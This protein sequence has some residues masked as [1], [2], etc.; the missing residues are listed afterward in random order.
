MIMR[1][2]QI[3]SALAVV[4]FIGCNNNST[5]EKN[6]DIVETRKLEGEELVKRGHYLVTVATCGDCHSPKT[7][8][9]HGPVIDSTKMLSGSPAGMPLP[10]FNPNAVKPGNWMNMSPDITVFVGPWG[11]S[12]AANLTPDSATGIGTWTEDL[13]IKALRTGKHMGAENGRPILPPMPWEFV[14]KMT[15]EDLRSVFAYLKSLPAI[16]NKVRAPI[17]PNE[18]K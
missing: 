12:F 5:P 17:P 13:F 11:A 2:T 8:T 10:P 1:L 9:E 18:I 3:S 4:L 16:S 15:E 7:M 6:D 14:N